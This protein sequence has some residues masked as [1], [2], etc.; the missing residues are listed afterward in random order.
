MCA[1]LMGAFRQFG[2]IIILAAV[3]KSPLH[4]K[5]LPKTTL[6]REN[7]SALIYR[8]MKILDEVAPNSPIL[9][10]DLKI[11]DNVKKELNLL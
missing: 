10:M 5:L 6:N 9:R 7:L 3:Y 4:R 11:L 2:N 8:T 1:V